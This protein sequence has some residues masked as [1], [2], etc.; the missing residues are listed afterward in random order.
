MAR[1]EPQA[2]A[3]RTT[4]SP[5]PR[6]PR[7]SWPLNVVV[8]GTG[9][10]LHGASLLGVALG[11]LYLALL[12]AT[13]AGLVLF[14]DDLT[15]WTQVLPVLT[16]AV[17]GLSQYALALSG[18]RRQS[19]ARA[20][21]RRAALA[22][23]RERLGQGAPDEALAALDPIANLA[24]SDLTVAY[25]FAQARMAMRDLAAA[26]QAWALVRKLDRHGIYR[27]ER[28]R[29]EQMVRLAQQS[30]ARGVPEA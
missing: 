24:A 3:D 8:P 12:N 6:L 29:C 23:A 13:V 21:L 28:E 22:R 10:I 11:L 1:A 15:G 17:W 14:P 9:L 19:R 27:S 18:R 2:R 26:E 25:R 30:S 7:W 4:R 5:R 20:S 16:V